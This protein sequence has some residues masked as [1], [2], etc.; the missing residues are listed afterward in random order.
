MILLTSRINDEIFCISYLRWCHN[1]GHVIREWWIPACSYSERCNFCTLSVGFISNKYYCS[2][3]SLA[4]FE[5]VSIQES[6]ILPHSVCHAQ[7][8]CS[9][10]DMSHDTWCSYM[11]NKVPHVIAECSTICCLAMDG[12]SFGLK[13]LGVLVTC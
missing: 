4:S 9:S 11:L 5:D 10:T 13:F 7:K 8:F 12:Q 3:I 1:G 6:K 2:K